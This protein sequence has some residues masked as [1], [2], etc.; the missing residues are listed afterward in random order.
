MMASRATSWLTTR[1]TAYT[2]GAVLGIGFLAGVLP[3]EQFVFFIQSALMFSTPLLF[4]SLGELVA[5]K[6]GLI[7]IGLEG[8]VL[9]GAFGGFAA[10]SM[11]G[12]LW[13]GVGA[14]ILAGLLFAALFGVMCVSLRNDQIVTGAA[15]NFLALG[16]TG[17]LYRVSYG[18]TGSTQTVDPFQPWDLPVLSRLP[19]L[20]PA[21]F[22]QTS[23][24]YL[25]L[26]IGVLLAA[27]F[28]YTRL[29]FHLA[30]VGEHPRAADAAGIPVTFVRWMAVLYEG[31]LG[32]LAG[33]TL[34]LASSN[35]FNEEMSNGR[36]FIAIAIVIFGR[37]TPL[38]TVGAALFFGAAESLQLLLQA[39]EKAV[40]RENYPYLQMLPYLVT[41]LVLTAALGKARPPRAMGQ[42]YH[43]E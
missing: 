6:V 26:L 16:A 1:R 3:R 30:A 8:Y 39:S 4:A 10:A 9:A 38:G 14:A 32:G 20:G 25:A 22:G 31:V 36:G 21:L 7:N 29:G 13:L 34:S 23:L 5:Q 28:R 41:L 12:S 42:H 40:L 33:A 2:L 17:L 18:A 19:Y 24:T 43:R 11:S 37:W 35:T 15:L 27:L